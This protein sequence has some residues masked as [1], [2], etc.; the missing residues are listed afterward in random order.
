MNAQAVVVFFNCGFGDA[1][2]KRVEQFANA[3][4]LGGGGMNNRFDAQALEGV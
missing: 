3:A 1:L 2:Y 4:A